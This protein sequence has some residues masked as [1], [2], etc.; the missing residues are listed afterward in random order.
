MPNELAQEIFGTPRAMAMAVLAILS[1]CLLVAA[2][3]DLHRQR[4]PNQLV[5]SGAL[6][7]LMLH[8]TLP[9][10]DGFLA[11][12]PGG[13]GFTESLKGLAFG[14]LAFLPFY[15]LR[16]TGAGDVK[17]VAMVGAFL[18]PVELWWAL[19]FTLFAGG[20]LAVAVAFYRGVLGCVLQNMRLIFW[21]VLFTIS[22]SSSKGTGQP[23]PAFISAAPLPYA[24]AIAAGSIA[25]VIYRAQH[26]GLL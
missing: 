25:A 8:T 7:A 13:L 16:A 1:I 24:V 6:L 23:E 4:I 22:T 10:G 14:L 11:G 2:W 15:W 20:V 26:A 9:A 18:G 12:L 3:T 17:L 19:F 21:D 5:F